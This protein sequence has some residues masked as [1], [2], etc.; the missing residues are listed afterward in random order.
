MV[1]EISI[2]SMVKKLQEDIKKVE[3]FD[4]ANGKL[5]I[6]AINKQMDDTNAILDILEAKFDKVNASL[7]AMLSQIE[8]EEKKRQTIKEETEEELKEN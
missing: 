3:N 5:D 7:D 2:D 1:N 4:D 8:E 6:A